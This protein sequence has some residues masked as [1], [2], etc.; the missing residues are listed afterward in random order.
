MTLTA[1]QGLAPE[2]QPLV[3]GVIAGQR[4]ALAKAI[5]LVESKLESH[6]EQAQVVLEQVL[7]RLAR[8]VEVLFQANPYQEAPLFRGFYFTSGTQEGRPIDSVINAML[9]AAMAVTPR[10]MSAAPARR[11]ASTP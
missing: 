4:R 3:E 11:R 9:R 8:F 10:A 2:D 1:A 7:P 5:T 6:R